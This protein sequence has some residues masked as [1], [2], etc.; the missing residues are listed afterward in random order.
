MQN[1]RIKLYEYLK[2]SYFIEY[3]K[4]YNNHYEYVDLSKSFN[5]P[6]INF[7]FF[8]TLEKS[9]EGNKLNYYGKSI[10]IEEVVIN[11][12][13]LK[14]L[15]SEYLESLIIKHNIKSCNIKINIPKDNLVSEQLR[16]KIINEMYVDLSYSFENIKKNFK[17]SHRTILNK[18]YE[19]LSYEIINNKNYNNEILEMEKMHVEVS[20]KRTR[21]AKSW[22][23]NAKMIKNNCAFL[24]KAKNK[25][26]VLSYN[27]FFFDCTTTIYFASVSYR[28]Y[29]KIYKNLGHASIWYAI[30]YSK[31]IS[32]FLYLGDDHLTNSCTDKEKNIENFK[33]GFCNF[34]KRIIIINNFNDLFNS[35]ENIK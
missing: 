33:K 3:Q 8:L 34:K 1:T 23:L 9:Q 6:K 26:K 27:F 35:L 15:I 32:K 25:E 14:N 19:D 13:L 20:G 7:F 16:S 4:E 29:F 18:T 22:L 5:L 21:S 10:Q 12:F 30:K 31:N 17:Q 28:E 11:N 24:I 2:N